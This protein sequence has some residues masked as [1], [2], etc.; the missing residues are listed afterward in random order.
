MRGKFIAFEGGD[1][2][3]KSSAVAWLKKELAGEPI[4]FTREPGGTES[5]EEMRETLVKQ[6]DEDLDVLTQILL[7]EAGRR[8]HMLKKIIPALERGEHVVCDR[9]AASTYGYQII[10][11]N[12]IPFEKVFRE[13]D[14]LVRNGVEPDL[15]IFLDVDPEVGIARKRKSG[16][17]LNTF[18]TKELDFY[19]KVREGIQH[20]LS[21]KP[22]IVVDANR[23]LDEVRADIRNLVL[24]AIRA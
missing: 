3:G 2:S 7:F 16:D 24:E 5:A 4:I 10:G 8:E 13:L 11:G 20:Y 6:R 12:G 15:T 18:D 17:A 9:F 19:M 14:P 23:P 1:G 21:D 22:H